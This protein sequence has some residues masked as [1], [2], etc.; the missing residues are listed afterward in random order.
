VTDS[1]LRSSLVVFS[2]LIAYPIQ[3]EIPNLLAKLCL[4]GPYRPGTGKPMKHD[5]SK[6]I[7]NP[8]TRLP[9][10]NP[11]VTARHHRTGRCDPVATAR[12]KQLGDG[13]VEI[14]GPDLSYRVR[15]PS[16]Q[17]RKYYK[18]KKLPGKSRQGRPKQ[19]TNASDLPIPGLGSR[20]SE[21]KIPML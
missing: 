4:P 2:I 14:P 9:C 11:P 1:L 16:Y 8:N 6:K 13:Q 15:V 12:N 20:N 21:T 19:I 3:I 10:L 5:V 18:H 7:R 17:P